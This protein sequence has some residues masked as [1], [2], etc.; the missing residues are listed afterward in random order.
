MA[1]ALSPVPAPV[2]DAQTII[3]SAI[4]SNIWGVAVT[5]Q[6]PSGRYQV[7]GATVEARSQGGSTEKLGNVTKPC[8][9]IDTEDDHELWG[10]L[11]KNEGAIKNILARFSAN[12]PRKGLHL[13]PGSQVSRMLLHLRE[14][15]H[16]R[17]DLAQRLAAVWHTE[18]IPHLQTKY[19]GHFYLLAPVLP[20]SD[21]LI[22]RFDTQWFLTPLTVTSASALT[23]DGLSTE[24]KEGIIQESDN[25]ARNLVKQRAQFIYEQVF[26]E[27]VTQCDEI[28]AGAM[29][30]GKR[31]GG[32]IT[33]L[34]TLLDRLRN[35]SEFATPEVLAKAEEAMRVMSTVTDIAAINRNDGDNH[36][37]RAVKAAFA[38]LGASINAMLQDV[39][40]ERGRSQRKVILGA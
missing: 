38:P 37:V 14:A 23:F 29:E 10:K 26:G 5:V 19:N 20:H 31:K 25:M 13:V 18:L 24:D 11:D 4:P 15:R 12:D 3:E 2:A 39:L 22:E 17:L 21:S 35:F 28:A 27:V 6:R 33:E 9:I 8:F 30:S 34:V 36:V 7:K 1:T 40:P 32:C 16:E